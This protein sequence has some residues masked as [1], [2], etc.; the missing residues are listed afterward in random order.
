MC[1][2]VV[3]GQAFGG[4][5][6]EQGCVSRNK[7]AETN[8]TAA[9]LERIVTLPAAGLA[10]LRTQALPVSFKYCLTIALVSAKKMLKSYPPDLR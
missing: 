5:G 7:S 2:W 10:Q 9:N 8:L 6:G 1:V 4:S 3:G